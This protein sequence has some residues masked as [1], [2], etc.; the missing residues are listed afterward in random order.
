MATQPSTA[1]SPQGVDEPAVPLATAARLNP[2]RTLIVT[3]G[4]DILTESVV[5]SAAQEAGT[6]SGSRYDFTPMFSGLQSAT[7]NAD[8]AIC[9][10]ELPIGGPTQ[11][12]GSYGRSPFGGNLV[13]S[14]FELAAGVRAAG[15]DRCSTASNHSFDLGAGGIATTLEALDASGI[16]HVGTARNPWESLPV[17]F[18]VNGVNVGHIS[19][20]RWSNTVRPAESWRLNYATST[21]QIANDVAALRNAGAEIILVSLHLSRELQQGPTSID[22]A[23]T[24]QLTAVAEIDLVV[25]HG[26]HVVQPIELINDTLVYWSLGNMV[27]G[28]GVAGRGPYEDPRTLDGLMANVRFL[29]TTSGKWMAQPYTTATCTDPRTRLVRAGRSALDDP[30][31]NFDLE[32]WAALAQ[33]VWRTESVVGPTG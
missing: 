23:F 26:P 17:V 11:A 9:H 3:A 7:A 16:S 20:T 18:E 4:G 13:P 30:N 1:V 32:T 14:P 21:T 2:P 19:Y 12:P 28:M 8:L 22:R 31:A 5:R 25:H 27:S 10:M 15:F 6:E 33:C 29:E 24:T